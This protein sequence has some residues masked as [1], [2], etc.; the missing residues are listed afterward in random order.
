MNRQLMSKEHRNVLAGSKLQ[1]WITLANAKESFTQCEEH[2]FG[3][4]AKISANR[5]ACSRWEEP[6]IVKI[7][8]SWVFSLCL[9]GKPYIHGCCELVGWSPIISITSQYVL[10]CKV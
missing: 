5:L 1:F 4:G 2:N 7:G 10:I 9:L 3:T 8:L 6:I